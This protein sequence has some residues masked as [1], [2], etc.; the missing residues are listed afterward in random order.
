MTSLGT[1]IVID[2]GVMEYEP[3]PRTM[4]QQKGCG[5]DATKPTTFQVIHDMSRP[6]SQSLCL[7]KT[8]PPAIAEPVEPM[9]ESPLVESQWRLCQYLGHRWWEDKQSKDKYH[10]PLI[11]SD[12]I[13][14]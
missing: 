12:F 4:F 11:Q 5:N 3:K 7:V 10:S 13:Q 1:Q 14:S 8:L 6:R 2:D 9:L